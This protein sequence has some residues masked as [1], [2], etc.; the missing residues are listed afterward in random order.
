MMDWMKTP[1]SALLCWKRISQTVEAL[2]LKWLKEGQSLQLAVGQRVSQT[3]IFLSIEAHHNNAF[4]WQEGKLSRCSLWETYRLTSTQSSLI[5][6]IRIQI[7]EQDHICNANPV[8]VFL[9]AACTCG[10]YNVLFCILHT[11]SIRTRALWILISHFVI[12][13]YPGGEV[14]ALECE[15]SVCLDVTRGSAG[16][17]HF[18][19]SGD[20]SGTWLHGNMING[21]WSRLPFGKTCVKRGSFP[22]LTVECATECYTRGQWLLQGKEIKATLS[23]KCQYN[24][25]VQFHRASP[26]R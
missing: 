6:V 13:R 12:S 21:A 10:R 7:K 5:S 3:L 22:L 11:C 23:D 24:K 4:I 25:R 8:D 26:C 16:D 9:R 17:L 18:S 19:I 15:A 14:C 2:G 20:N 1:D